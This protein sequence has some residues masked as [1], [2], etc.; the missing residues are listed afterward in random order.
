M[1]ASMGEVSHVSINDFESVLDEFISSKEISV[2]TSEAAIA[3]QLSTRRNSVSTFGSGFLVAL[4]PLALGLLFLACMLLYCNSTSCSQRYII[5]Y[6][7]NKD[8]Q[9]A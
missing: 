7:H 8:G 1:P 2:S 5:R 4:L 6:I 9:K 3:Q